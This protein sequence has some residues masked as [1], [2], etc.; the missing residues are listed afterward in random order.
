MY[1]FNHQEALFLMNLKE[2]CTCQ[3]QPARHCHSH[4]RI[5]FFQF[6]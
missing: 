4:R 1:E 3:L 2:E 5:L 6:N